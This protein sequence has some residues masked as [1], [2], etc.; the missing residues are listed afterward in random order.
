MIVKD[1]RLYIYISDRQLKI[2][3]NHNSV[4]DIIILHYGTDLYQRSVIMG[5]HN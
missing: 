2:M 3:D 5:S 4:M 1:L